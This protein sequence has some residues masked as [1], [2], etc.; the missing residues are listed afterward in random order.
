MSGG[1]LPAVA[2]RTARTA[3]A[4]W[5]TRASKAAAAAMTAPKVPRASKAPLVATT[6]T[7]WLTVSSFVAFVVAEHVANN[8]GCHQT[9]NDTQRRLRSAAVVAAKQTLLVR[10]STCGGAGAVVLPDDWRCHHLSLLLL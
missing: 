5:T 8:L 6:E 3:R 10:G 9:T 1:R 4:T 2:T 7:A